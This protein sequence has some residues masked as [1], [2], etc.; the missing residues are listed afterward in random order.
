MK[1]IIN[2]LVEILRGMVAGLATILTSTLLPIHNFMYVIAGLAML[3]MVVGWIADQLDFKM[4]KALKSGVYLGGF[5]ILLMITF[6]IGKLMGV[7]DEATNVTSWITWVMIWFYAIKILKNWKQ[8][9]PDNTVVAILYYVV[10]IEFIK[11]IKYLSDFQEHE[12]NNQDG[13]D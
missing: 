2:A 5:F 9:Q 12:K 3:N 11:R 13:K 1:E 4:R 6:S 8:I 7:Q 10:A